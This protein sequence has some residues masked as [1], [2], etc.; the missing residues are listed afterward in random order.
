LEIVNAVDL[1]LGKRF[2]SIRTIKFEVV[3]TSEGIV[4]TK[5]EIV[6]STKTT[7]NEG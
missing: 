4:I 7:T 5:E 6:S 2:K 1:H 3:E